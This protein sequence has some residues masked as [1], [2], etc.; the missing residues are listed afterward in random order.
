MAAFFDRV[1]SM[2]PQR[3]REAHPEVKRF[4][5]FAIV[6]G[7]GALLD[8]TVLNVLILV[9]GV[10]K[11]VANIISVC[12]AIISNFTWNRLW[13]F[14]ESREH[15]VHSQLTKFVV[16]NLVGLAINQ[17]VFILTDNLIFLPLMPQH[18]T[19][20]YNLAKACAIGVVL[21]WNFGINR[22]WTYRHVKFG[23]EHKHGVLE[24]EIPPL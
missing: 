12:C 11:E 17:L 14:P 4:I 8:V 7:I 1:N 6:G 5:K 24:D 23:E 9:V 18:E 20:A 2:A 21:F 3:V 15:A 19:I 22:I 13:T 16:V 10:P